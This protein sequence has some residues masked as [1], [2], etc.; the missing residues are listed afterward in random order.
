MVG[1]AKHRTIDKFRVRTP[2]G[3][4]YEFAEK[5]TVEY[6][7]H[8][9]YKYSGMPDQN[10]KTVTAWHLTKI[11]NPEKTDSIEITYSRGSTWQKYHGSS[12]LA[13]RTYT[14][15]TKPGEFDQSGGSGGSSGG[16]EDDDGF[17]F[18]KIDLDNLHKDDD[19]YVKELSQ[20]RAGGGASYGTTT[21]LRPA[22]PISIKSKNGTIRLEFEKSGS[23]HTISNG[24][25]N[26][27]K[28]ITLTSPDNA[29]V[30]SADFGE[31]ELNDGRRTLASLRINGDKGLLEGYSF[32]YNDMN[33]QSRDFFGYPNGK[34][35]TG[36]W[37]SVVATDDLK[38]NES[39][40]WNGSYIHGGLLK[41]MTTSMGITTSF[42]YEP[43]RIELE[44]G[45]TLF[46]NEIVIGTGLRSITATDNVTQRQRVRTFE[47]FAP[48]L[49]ADI[50]RTG[51]DEFLEPS[52]TVQQLLNGLASYYKYEM[53]V[54]FTGSSR[55]PGVPME[56][57]RIYY[58]AVEE[59]VSGQD[60]ENP[61]K[62]RYE[63]DL[64][65]SKIY[66]AT[67]GS[68]IGNDG[69][70]ADGTRI[71][72]FDFFTTGGDALIMQNTFK[73]HEIRYYFE[74]CIGCEPLL[75]K[76]ITYRQVGGS[77]Q[78]LTTESHTYAVCDTMEKKVGLYYDH[79]AFRVAETGTIRNTIDNVGHVNY[80]DIKVRSKRIIHTGSSLTRHYGEGRERTSHTHYHYDKVERPQKPLELAPWL[81]SK[82]SVPT[83]WTHPGFE[84]AHK[85]IFSELEKPA[86][87]YGVTHSCMG[88]SIS[89]YIK[90][91]SESNELGVDELENAPWYLP[92]ARR[93]I[94]H[95]KGSRTLSTRG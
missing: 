56:N 92:V 50:S 1:D 61:V 14:H 66:S 17:K 41:S 5:D 72:G 4:W 78:P 9:Y 95:G 83:Y 19:D 44:K 53:S 82:A 75:S 20:S 69:Y 2:D 10:Y 71:L 76:K 74:E 3:I 58:G 39:R 15:S 6:V 31:G 12:A 85:N 42:D 27:L 34:P 73:P 8:A 26:R 13:S 62:T 49:N 48:E 36:S 11:I 33:K 68:P 60:M 35:R 63:Y 87:P 57:T 37:E 54:V 91:I 90:Y 24:T 38:L 7:Y 30:R 81:K 22:L 84:E 43:S 32:A 51:Y 25:A 89:E 88:D 21:Y 47:Y 67:C 23:Q 18:I 28:K 93:Q 52:G 59:T 55:L 65:E 40:R 94:A 46:G 86:K 77:Y 64:S 45:G 16:D 70:E 80:G 29:T 79:L